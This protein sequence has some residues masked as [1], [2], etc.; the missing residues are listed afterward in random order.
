MFDAIP[1]LVQSIVSFCY[2]L[3]NRI[4][5]K[6]KEWAVR[7]DRKGD[8]L[9]LSRPLSLPINGPWST[10][11]SVWALAV[12]AVA[13]GCYINSKE[14]AHFPVQTLLWIKRGENQMLGHCL[15]PRRCQIITCTSSAFTYSFIPRKNHVIL[16][17]LYIKK[18]LNKY[19]LYTWHCAT[20]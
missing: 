12:P 6:S 17:L 10:C 18:A 2:F 4:K 5:V 11:L 16:F 8:I 9:W 15:T 3:K 20:K 7:T 1:N 13:W 19:S 14:F